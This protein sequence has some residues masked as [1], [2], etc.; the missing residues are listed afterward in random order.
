MKANKDLTLHMD[1]TILI[2]IIF[3]VINEYKLNNLRLFP[4]F[5]RRTSRFM[6]SQNSAIYESVVNKLAYGKGKISAKTLNEHLTG[7]R[8]PASKSLHS[9]LINMQFI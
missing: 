9:A 8:E 4:T 5:G 1:S 7:N 3:R 2:S 6:V